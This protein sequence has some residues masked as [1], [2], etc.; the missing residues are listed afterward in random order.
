MESTAL[1]DEI[2]G[3]Q[4]KNSKCVVCNG[5]Q[6]CTS[7]VPVWNRGPFCQRSLADNVSKLFTPAYISVPERHLAYFVG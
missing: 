3:V 6:V 2:L 1:F 7:S 4:E 5:Q